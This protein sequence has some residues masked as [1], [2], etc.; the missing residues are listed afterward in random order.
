MIRA[1]RKGHK[2]QTRR[3][4]S[5]GNSLVDGAHAK[6]LL[7][8]QLNFDAASIKPGQAANGNP[9]PY[10]EIPCSTNRVAHRI[11][12]AYRDGSKIWVKETFAQS[13]LADGTPVVTYRAGGSIATGQKDPDSPIYLL[14]GYAFDETPE[15][16]RWHPSIFMPRWASRITLGVTNVRIER[17]QDISEADCWAEGIEEV[18][19]MFDDQ[20]PAMA[21]HIG[22]PYEDAKPTYACLWESFYGPGSWDANPFVWKI[23]FQGIKS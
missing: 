17:L 1:L 20:I 4:L 6:K 9:N 7:W 13:D 23:E 8:D 3:I 2:T 15:P 19:G 10:L 14:H 18:D 22:C 11:D 12:P 5:R 21:K 16:V